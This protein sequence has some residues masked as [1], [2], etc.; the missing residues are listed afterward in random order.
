MVRFPIDRRRA[1]E[2]LAI[3]LFFV[4]LT[5][6]LT[7]P[8]ARNLDRAVSDPGDPYITTFTLA[9]VHHSLVH[10]MTRLFHAPIFHPHRYT[11]AFSEN[12]IGVAV[13]TL[14]LAIAGVDPLTIHNIALLAGFVFTG[15]S[16]CLMGRL[17]TG[18]LLGGIG[19]GL[20][21]AF[22][23]WRYVHLSH[24]Q[25]QWAG[26]LPLLVA[27]IVFYWLRPAPGRALLVAFAFMA[28][29]LTNMHWLAFSLV[30]APAVALTAGL[31]STHGRSWRAWLGILGAFTAGGAA[32]LPILHPYLRVRQL[33]AM[34]SDGGESALWS[35]YPLDWLAAAP[36]SLYSR[37]WPLL[38][39][40]PERWLFPGILPSIL[41]LFAL[42]ALHRPTG[43]SVPPRSGAW[44]TGIVLLIIGFVAS[45]GSNAPF[46]RLLSE[47]VPLFGG[48]RAPARWAMIGYLGMAI[49]IAITLAAI[50]RLRRGRLVAAGLLALLVV[51]LNQAPVRYWLSPPGADAITRR[52]HEL[53]DQ[54]VIAWLP[55]DQTSQ[56]RRMLD[57]ARH[58]A[59]MVN[60][61]SGFAPPAYRELEASY[62]SGELGPEFTRALLT[63]GTSAVVISPDALN[64]RSDVV[65]EWVVQE[66]AKGRM[67]PI[68]VYPSE[69]HAGDF[70]FALSASAV[71][72]GLDIPAAIAAWLERR[73]TEPPAFIFGYVDRPAPG[74]VI[75]GDLTISGWALA[76]EPIE[77][78]RV[79]LE[80]GGRT[81]EAERFAQPAITRHFAGF[82][83]ERQP[84]FSLQLPH[85]ERK[86]RRTDVEIEVTT[87]GGEVERVGYRWFE[88]R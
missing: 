72:Q 4:V 40:E 81:F 83:H 62:L 77:R 2:E 42:F 24:L 7:W 84:G 48:I 36:D 31:G 69:L 76:K 29:G 66:M 30:A 35:A 20:F 45:L 71:E 6:L 64:E 80:N 32:L 87:V 82:D 55:L 14:P 63:L 58:L 86:W 68:A 13:P 19:A 16:A 61:V 39:T 41:T 65:R 22:L 44:M 26:W 34:R 57:A 10:D 5:H 74:E 52:A 50:V 54:L 59:P 1:G 67:R 56:Y 37:L 28:N 33:Y 70:V 79:L 12:L 8:L 78:V 15:W 88:W 21:F 23:P 18:S 53:R 27:A 51:E 38:T 9:W 3:V 17:L 25:H 75:D 49:L 43:A 73:R 47:T 85:S 60:G 46:H 11:L